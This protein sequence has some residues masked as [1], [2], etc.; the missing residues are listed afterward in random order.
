MTRLLVWA[1]AVSSA[2]LVWAGD[3]AAAARPIELVAARVADQAGGSRLLDVPYLPQT[4]D[5][6]GGAAVAM[7]LRYWGER[8]IYP[9]DFAELIDRGASGIRTDVLAADVSR[10]G[11]HSFSL[12]AGTGSRGEWVREH[13]NQGRPIVALIE[14]RPNRYHYVVVVAWT[15]AQVVVHDPARE[16]FRVMSRTEFDR[17]WAPAGRWALLVLP[18]EDRPSPPRTRLERSA[19]DGSPATGAC[20][21][22]VQRMVALARAGAIGDAEAGLLTAVSLCPLDP[23]AWREL[24]G[25]RFLQSRWSEASTFAERAGLL[26][27]G[28]EQTWDLLATS[29]FLNNEP[30]AALEAWNR[31]GR[32]SVDLVQVDGARRTRAPVIA[33]LVDLP[34]HTLL[35]AERR[36][37][38]A[39]RLDELPSAT[40]TDLRYRPVDGG[41][42]E[43]EVVIVERSIIPR[44]VVTVAAMLARAWLQREVRLDVAAPAGSGEL[45]T[46]EWRW[47]EA[48]PRLAFS[49]AVPVVSFLPGITTIEGSW[50]RPS[51]A[52]RHAEQA[53]MGVISRDERRRA[54]FTLADWATSGVHWKTGVALDRW[55][56]DSHLSVDV[57]LDVRLASDRMSIGIDTAVWAPLGSG[58]RFAHAGVSSAWRSTRDNTRPSWLASGRLAAA[59]ASAPFDLWPGAGTGHARTPLLRAHPLLDAGVVTGPVFGRQLVHGTVEYAHPLLA[60]PIGAIQLGLFA[61]AARA[62]RRSPDDGRRSW[63]ADVGAGLRI[64][65]PGNGGTTRVDLARGLRDGR[66]V[67][68]AGWQPPWPGR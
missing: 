49:V 20:G 40:L 22:L 8:Q 47:W 24:A 39:R 33:A 68:S 46:A 41:W 29:R 23:A 11:W 59:S 44:G 26:D 37:R 25:V 12:D 4:E 15:D 55:A 62:W 43:I 64:A 16:P 45:W 31:V 53:E 61:D 42:A 10:R 21:A 66:V 63:H 54:A 38:A 57:A 30:D 7:V 50:E 27:P 52:V 5:L 48:R 13:V 51:Y 58:G 14:A 17:V 56:Q 60:T 1:V 18:P 32:L 67:L 65:L 36:G 34:P 6:C 2:L 9:E 3:A 28:D 35:T 19:T